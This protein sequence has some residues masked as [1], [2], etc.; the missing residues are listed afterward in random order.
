MPA[1]LLLTEVIKNTDE[2]VISAVDPLMSYLIHLYSTPSAGRPELQ[3]LLKV[4]D[5]FTVTSSGSVGF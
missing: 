2:F 3:L 4:D 1:S 5:S